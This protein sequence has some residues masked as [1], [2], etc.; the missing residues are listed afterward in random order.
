ML[1]TNM[2]YL[3]STPVEFTPY[4]YVAELFES[5]DDTVFFIKD[6]EGRYIACNDTLLTR[7][8]CKTRSELL[9]RKPSELLGLT[10]GGSYEDQD[11]RVMMQGRA[12]KE[13]LE[14]HI[15]MNLSTGWCLTTKF[16]L[17]HND[18]TVFGIMGISKD[19]K[20]AAMNSEEFEQI[21]PAIEY[22]TNNLDTPP[23]LA[24]LAR[25]VGLTPYQL[26]RRVQKVFGLTAGQ[27]ILKQRLDS[28]QHQLSEM[29]D[30]I[31]SIALNIG[32]ADQSAFSRQFRKT[33][34]VSPFVYR[35]LKRQSR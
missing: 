1:E 27:W 26:D 3:Q 22:V 6:L 8:N 29:D 18:G 21:S 16:P 4:L 32:Y 34:G 9:G 31:A 11:Q 10:L 20:P 13:L 15:Y 19:L 14:V 25:I 35:Q 24:R 12:I 2:P 7:T 5:Y 30:S 23:S 17:K 33:I 28:A